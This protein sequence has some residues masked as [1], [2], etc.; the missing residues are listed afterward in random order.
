MNNKLKLDTTILQSNT[1]HHLV[2][3]IVEQRKF[4]KLLTD[5]MNRDDVKSLNRGDTS[6]KNLEEDFEYIS[7][8]HLDALH[9]RIGTNIYKFE[10]D[11]EE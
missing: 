2:Q 10:E 11:E 1:A 7:S 4:I 3:F 6:L 8:K 9:K 5:W